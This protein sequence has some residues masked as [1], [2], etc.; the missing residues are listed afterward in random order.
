MDLPSPHTTAKIEPVAGVEVEM[1]DTAIDIDL[2]DIKKECVEYSES[3]D[4]TAGKK[5]I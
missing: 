1:P 5:C 3:R 4:S 2:P